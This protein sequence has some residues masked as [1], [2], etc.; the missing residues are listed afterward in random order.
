MSKHRFK[1]IA[2]EM[3][4]PLEAEHGEDCNVA[5]LSDWAQGIV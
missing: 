2:E 1:K 5:R 3:G 4:G